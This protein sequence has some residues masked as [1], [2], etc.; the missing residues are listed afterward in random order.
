MAQDYVRHYESLSR[1]LRPRLNMAEQPIP[2]PR[3]RIKQPND[4][5][6]R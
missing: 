5:A 3:R 4:S 1:S 6:F 2:M